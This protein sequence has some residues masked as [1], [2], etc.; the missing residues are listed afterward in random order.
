MN[1]LRGSAISPGYAE[2]TVIIYRPP[3]LEI[4]ER[5]KIL[6][7]DVET[8][9]QRFTAAIEHSAKEVSVVRHQVATDVGETEAAIFDAHI[10]MIRDPSL[11]EQVHQ[12]L[13]ED[14]VCAETALADQM[15]IFS[16]RLASSG[17]D[18]MKE[19]ALDVRDVGNRLLRHLC[20]DEGQTSLTDLPKNSIIVA[21]ALLPSETVGM[22]QNQVAGIATEQGGPTS[23]AAILARSL[24]IPAVTGLIGLM[25]QATP[26]TLCLLDG[27]KGSLTLNPSDSQKRQFSSRRRQ[28]EQ[29]QHLMRQM[30]SRLCRLKNG[31]SIQLLANI[32]QPSDVDCANEHN[33]DGVGLYRTE[34]MYLSSPSA[35]TH[36]TQYR[37]YRRAAEAMSPHPIT[38]RTFDFAIDK[39]PD[40][41]SIDTNTSLELRGL[42]F[43]LRYPRLFKTQI[44]AI[45]RCACDFPNTRILFPMVTGWWELQEALDIVKEISAEEK[46]EHPLLIGA[47]IETPAAVFSLPEIVK[48]VDFISI[49]CNDLAQYTL[50]KQRTLSSQTV[51]ECALHPSLLRAILQIVQT[52]EEANCPVCICGEAASDPIMVAIFA[53]LG[54]REF[55]VSPARAPIV[56]YA[57]RH[58]SFAEAKKTADSAMHSAPAQAML[59]L[60]AIIP[61]E[62]RKI[63]SLEPNQNMPSKSAPAKH[64]PKVEEASML[65]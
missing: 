25:D 27:T 20:I 60:Q 41:L 58:L 34:L 10:A 32:N 12:R 9:F 28:F 39:H 3:L 40:F 14:L 47:M 22:D 38:I 65:S 37:H 54:L 29:S 31:P 43:A 7:E 52:A 21:K 19:L 55:S 24:G 16:K 23:H 45:V 5:R 51:S 59:D 53:G 42:Q 56:R 48:M 49:G 13:R 61:E 26:D 18:Y 33:L 50:A 4:V 62:L 1:T 8:E 64:L 11:A 46:L 2:G 36:A 30:E 17:N 63:L 15:K 57:L 44:R 6:P 35:P